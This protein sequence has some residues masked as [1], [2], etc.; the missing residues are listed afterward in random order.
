MFLANRVGLRTYTVFVTES[1][2][3]HTQTGAPSN[4]PHQFGFNMHELKY[5]FSRIV[6]RRSRMDRLLISGTET[7]KTKTVYEI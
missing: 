5:P 2:Q 3:P 4:R 7:S 6:N 1:A